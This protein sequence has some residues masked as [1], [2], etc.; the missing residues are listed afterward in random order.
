MFPGSGGPIISIGGGGIEEPEDMK[1]HLAVGYD[2]V[3]IG[4]AVMGSTRA[5]EFIRV[6]RDRTLLP[7]ELSQWGLEDV[8]FDMD[9][10]TMPGPKSDVP[11][12]YDDEAYQ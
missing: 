3:V 4:K 8:E 9:G 12:P 1:R 11:D 10:N 5:P 6:V 2:A 7:A